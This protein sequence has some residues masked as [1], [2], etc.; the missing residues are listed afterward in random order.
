MPKRLLWVNHFAVPP[1]RGGGTRHFELARE[2][3]VLG[4]DVTVAASDFD[5]LTRR[6]ARRADSGDV[7]AIGEEVDGVKFRWLHAP[8]YTGNDWRR[9]SNWLGFSRSLMR[10][11]ATDGERPSVVI[12]SSPHLF[13]AEAASRLARRYRVPFVLEVRDLW[14]ESLQVKPG[15]RGPAYWAL[16]ALA[17]RL[18]ARADRIVVLAEGVGEYLAARGVPRSKI[19]FAP[20][21]VSL[22]DF[23]GAARNGAAGF[24]LVYAGAHGP[25]NG[26][27]T[28]I[29]AAVLLK[30][31]PDV[32]VLLVG[33]GPAKAEL[34]R[35]ATERGATNVTFAP[36]V[37]KRD[38][39]ALLSG[40]DA[41]LMVLKPVPLFSFGVSP[42]KLFDYWG[43]GLPVVNNVG[44]EVAE[45]V[46]RSG[47]GVQAEP[48]AR[49]LADAILRLRA[50][51]A[52]S[53]AAM[54]ESGRAWVREH[55]D[56]PVV[57]ASLSTALDA[58][59]TSAA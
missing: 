17:R 49:S 41:G 54:G 18:Y 21:G 22:D 40:Q 56:R 14:P 58:L 38:M 9:V 30:D 20:N 43:A 59:V 27:E 25:A 39:P 12:G 42:N 15:R 53:R 36:P 51:C 31:V 50:V 13:A 45:L 33:D 37:P 7:R 46:R 28:V 4:W 11:D 55:R 5:L 1:D 44:G 10:A 48:D 32:R 52:D 34:Q 57:A 8:P 19:V 16:W 6:Y 35:V 24:G 3:R 26:L 29:D 2:L 23:G 47:G